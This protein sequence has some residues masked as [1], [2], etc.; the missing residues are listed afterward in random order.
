MITQKELKNKYTYNEFTGIFRYKVNTKHHK[1]G[2]IC[3]TK[4]GP[5][6]ALYLK[7][8]YHYAHRLAW[9][10]VYG[11][12]PKNQIDHK[13]QIKI[14]N[15]ISNLR[16]ATRIQNGRN[17]RKPKRNKSG[18]KGVHWNKHIEKW[19]AYIGYKN[20]MK[21]LGNF[22]NLEEAYYHRLAAEQC[23]DWNNF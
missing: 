23:L 9:L 18:V 2:D 8:Q 19:V 16:E 4:V 13:D 1:I 12:L 22:D 10:Y 5:Y 20:K 3:K 7:G 6:I 11:K 21:F 14:H 15:W 17:I